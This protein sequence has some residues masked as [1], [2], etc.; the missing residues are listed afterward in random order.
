MKNT[1]ITILVFL[2]LILSW[3]YAT[4]RI[5]YLRDS[6]QEGL[7]EGYR[8]KGFLIKD[9]YIEG[10]NNCTLPALQINPDGSKTIG[11]GWNLEGK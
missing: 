3:I 5:I 2:S 11:S 7:E 1:L 9:V 10:S 6:Y 8:S 4:D